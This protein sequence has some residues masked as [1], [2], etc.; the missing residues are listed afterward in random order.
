MSKFKVGD[1][2]TAI[3]PPDSATGRVG[4]SG[5]VKA[6][7]SDSDRLQIHV[8]FDDGITWAC[9]ENTL[10]IETKTMNIKEKFT[11]LFISEPLK[12]FIKAGIKTS[13]NMLT[14]EGEHIALNWLMNKPENQEAFNTEVVQKLLA[15]EETK[16]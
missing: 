5:V 6:V 8:N 13:D 11:G 9:E 12:S 2:V 15:D 14:T 7:G 3:Y 10:K 4:V 1:R 16:A